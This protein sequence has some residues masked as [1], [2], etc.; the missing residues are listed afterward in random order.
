MNRTG[1]KQ[2]DRRNPEN[3]PPPAIGPQP[4]HDEGHGREKEDII[5]HGWRK[6]VITNIGEHHISH[7][8]GGKQGGNGRHHHFFGRADPQT[9]KNK[10][11]EIIDCQKK[12]QDIGEGQAV[13]GFHQ[14]QT[15]NMAEPGMNKIPVGTCAGNQQMPDELRVEWQSAIIYEA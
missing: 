15:G 2:Q 7:G 1:H 5:K 13:D 3:M 11:T 12:N 14:R 9:G 8:G 4:D 6:R 10:Q